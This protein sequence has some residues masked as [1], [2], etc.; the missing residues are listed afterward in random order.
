MPQLPKYKIGATDRDVGNSAT[1]PNGFTVLNLR[2]RK[3]FVI[4]DGIWATHSPSISQSSLT[5]SP[6]S[7]SVPEILLQSWNLKSKFN[8]YVDPIN[9][10]DAMDGTSKRS[11]WLSTEKADSQTL[12]EG[13]RIG[14][15]LNNTWLLYRTQ[16]MTV[17][18]SELTANITSG[19]ANV[20]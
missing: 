10:N 6:S 17:D 15:L 16:D 1:Y 9:G 3:C 8:Y 12:L 11:A 7:S 5:S 19:G 2:N 14:Y 18:M 13:Q 4:V 20:F